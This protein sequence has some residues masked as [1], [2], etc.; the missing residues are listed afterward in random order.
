[1]SGTLFPHRPAEL[2]GGP[3]PSGTTDPRLAR[4]N[5]RTRWEL[6]AARWRA[7]ELARLVFGAETCVRVGS[8]AAT[9]GFRGLLHLEVPFRDLEAHRARERLFVHHA[10]GDDLL[11]RVPFIFV[12]M[13]LPSP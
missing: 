11:R 5:R 3:H 12:F 2:P 6:A 4:E 7:H 13:P 10:G 1:M 8:T 9:S